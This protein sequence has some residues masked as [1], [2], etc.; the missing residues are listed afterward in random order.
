MR[1]GKRA[2]VGGVDGKGTEWPRVMQRSQ[3]FNMHN[4]TLTNPPM[5][6]TDFNKATAR[7]GFLSN[8]AGS[9]TSANA[10][11]AIRSSTTTGAMT[12][13]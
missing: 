7:H 3:I 6:S 5:A 9:S 1:D 12:S 13:W 11:F 2:S 4:W 10:T 8:A